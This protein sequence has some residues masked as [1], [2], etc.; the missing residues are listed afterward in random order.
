VPSKKK[1]ERR[2]REKERE[3]ERER[4]RFPKSYH[5]LF[6]HKYIPST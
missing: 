3:R 1:K 4:E 2:E 5:A 6:S